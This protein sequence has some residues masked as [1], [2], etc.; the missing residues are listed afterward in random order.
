[1]P[2]FQR[3]HAAKLRKQRGGL[4]STRIRATPCETTGWGKSDLTL[5]AFVAQR[6][7]ADSRSACLQFAVSVVT[8]AEL[9]KGAPSSVYS[10]L[11]LEH[12]MFVSLPSLC[13]SRFGRTVRYGIPRTNLEN[14]APPWGFL[15]SD[16]SIRT[17]KDLYLCTMASA[18][19]ARFRHLLHGCFNAASTCPEHQRRRQFCI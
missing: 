9:A 10:W 16:D 13:Q 3:L 2:K 4:S 5:Q 19:Y 11:S 6:L 12:H 8:S 15:D 7:L 1:M 17:G 14:E 18:T